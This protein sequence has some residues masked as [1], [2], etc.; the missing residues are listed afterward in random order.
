MPVGGAAPTDPPTGNPGSSKGIDSERF[1]GPLS[2][3]KVKTLEIP[4][5]PGSEGNV[6]FKDPKFPEA[7]DPFKPEGGAEP[8]P[9]N[10]AIAAGAVGGASVSTGLVRSAMG[11]PLFIKF[12]AGGAKPPRP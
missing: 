6:S 1:S 10:G 3:V 5:L 9:P 11:L 4:G 7:E 8:N 2:K 12:G